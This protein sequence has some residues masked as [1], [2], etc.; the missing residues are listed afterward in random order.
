MKPIKK[1][2]IIL[3]ALF[4]YITATAAYFLPRNAEISEIEKWITVIVSYCILAALWW[5]LKHKEQIQ[6]KDHSIN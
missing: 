2:T 1:S 4:I 6:N 5:I 3:L